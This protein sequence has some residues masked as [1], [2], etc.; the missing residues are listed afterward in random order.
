MSTKELERAKVLLKAAHEL[1]RKCDEGPYVKNVLEET[2]NYDGTECDGYCL[3][4]DIE[5]FFEFDVND[6]LSEY[7]CS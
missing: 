1:L 2:A 4:G 5:H 3:G 7:F 6:P